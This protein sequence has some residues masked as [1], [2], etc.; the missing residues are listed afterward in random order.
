MKELEILSLGIFPVEIINLIADFHDYNKYYKPIHTKKFKFVLVDILVMGHI[1]E[2]NI[3]T[4]SPYYAR[5]CWGPFYHL[6]GI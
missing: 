6:I 4:L 2:S 3:H 1:F 5:V